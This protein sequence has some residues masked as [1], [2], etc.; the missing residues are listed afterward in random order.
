MNLPVMLPP[1]APSTRIDGGARSVGAGFAAR[2]LASLDP[3][4]DAGTP[5]P[6]LAAPEGEQGGDAPSPTRF[7]AL[8][9]PPALARTA[10]DAELPVPADGAGAPADD[11]E[12]ADADLQAPAGS[13]HRDAAAVASGLTL[14]TAQAADVVPVPAGEGLPPAEADRTAAA[15]HAAPS[16][17]RTVDTEGQRRSV[18]RDGVAP[19]EHVGVMPGDVPVATARVAPVTDVPATDVPVADAAVAD[20]PVVEAAVADVPVADVPVADAPV[21]EAAVTDAQAAAAQ[22]AGHASPHAG[23]VPAPA[24]GPDA[25]PVTPAPAGG[26][27]AVQGRRPG[28]PPVTAAAAPA[29]APAVEVTPEVATA[30]TGPA[31]S[32]SDGANPAD[33]GGMRHP[34][35]P[36]TSAV[37]PSATVDGDG[38]APTVHSAATT[39]RGGDTS[40]PAAPALARIVDLVERLR[41]EPPPQQ[42]VIDLDQFG[43]GKLIV[44][45]RGDTVVVEAL[46]PSERLDPQWQDELGAALDEHGWSFESDGQSREGRQHPSP[47]PDLPAGDHLARAA[48]A[49]DGHLRL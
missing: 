11:P 28:R 5:A 21:A 36:S 34:G 42:V 48:R 19:A 27:A 9:M 39:G 45:L 3:S 10:P 7:A 26:A 41:A 12:A 35:T 30:S 22:A 33:Q 14:G 31:T 40:A 43:V 46:D 15:V 20:V 49:A 18:P 8:M 6:A 29:E 13:G 24:T 16:M 44:S 38:A 32:P 17:P 4:V 1:P 23:H 25:Q 47:P 2:L 37:D